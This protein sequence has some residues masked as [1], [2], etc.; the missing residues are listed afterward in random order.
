MRLRVVGELAGRS[1]AHGRGRRRRGD[2]HH[3]R[4]ADARRR[5]RHRDGRTHR[6]ATA[7]T[8]CWSRWR[9][10]R[11]CTCAAPAATSK[12]ATWCSSPA[13]CSRRAHLG[14]L[15]TR[16][17]AAR[18]RLPARARRACCRPATSWWSRAPLEPGKIRDSNRPMLL[19]LLADAGAEPIDLGSAHDDADVMTAHARRR[20]RAVRRGDHERRSVGRRLRLRE[21]RA[22]AHRGRRSRRARRASTGTRWR[23]SRRS[24]CASAM[25]QGTP[26]FG[27][28]GNPVSSFVSFEL[29]ARPALRMMMGHDRPFRPRGQ[30]HRRDTRSGVG[31]TASSTSTV[32]SSRSSTA[33]TWRRGVRSQESNALAASAAAN[34]LRAPARRRRRRSR[35]PRHW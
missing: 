17:R 2:P 27:L 34:A 5:R 8:A 11:G 13:P 18:A 22:R 6:R 25:L 23:S 12:P 3:D 14:V 30:R 1:R 32:S 28:P 19:A 26:V 24:R 21:R 9:S 35:R 15:A 31:S 20:G 16:R 29:F 10:T 4:R 33:P 7:T